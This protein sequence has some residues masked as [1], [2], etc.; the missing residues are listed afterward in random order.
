MVDDIQ[1]IAP[2]ALIW[3]NDDT[4]LLRGIPVVSQ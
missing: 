3:L 2:A 1:T 4:A